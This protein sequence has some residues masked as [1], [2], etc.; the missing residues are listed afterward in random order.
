MGCQGSGGEGIGRSQPQFTLVFINRDFLCCVG[1]ARPFSCFL[2]CFCLARSTFWGSTP[3]WR[4]RA[5]CRLKLRPLWQCHPGCPAPLIPFSGHSVKPLWPQRT[6][7]Y[8]GNDLL[9]EDL[10]V[11]KVERGA[12]SDNLNPLDFLDL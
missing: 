11:G 6:A 2:R 1:I 12:V 5:P 10:R 9:P 8:L 4:E 3:V 7:S